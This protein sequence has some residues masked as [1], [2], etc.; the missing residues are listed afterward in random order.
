MERMMKKI[1][2]ILVF[3]MTVSVPLISQPTLTSVILPRYIQG[4]TGTNSDRIPSAYRVRITGLTSSASYR[5]Y[6]QIIISTDKSTAD[7]AGNCIFAS[8]SGD[9]IRTSSPSMATSGGYG[10]FLTDRS[11]NYE[12]W[13]I[14]EPTGNASRFVPGRFV[15]MRIMLN[16]GA[17]GT[18]VATRLTTSDSVQVV[19]LNTTVS[20]STGTGLR[21]TSQAI[22]KD[23]VFLYD[24][25]SGTGRPV[26]G[27][28]IESDGTTN[29]TTNS[30]SLFYATNV[31]NINGAFGVILPNILP[32]GIRRI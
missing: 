9:F 13:F 30:Y 14:N 22:P 10:S 4:N 26:S 24:N 31:D 12:G 29:S 20:D 2:T 11:G 17:S 16:D 8:S 6:N 18:T 3:F 32:T 7:G 1:V 23:F 27:S 28:L 19:K 21:C 25:T 5:Y 15:F